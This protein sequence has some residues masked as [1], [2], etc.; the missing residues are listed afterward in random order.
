[1][2]SF[3]VRA[4]TEPAGAVLLVDATSEHTGSDVE[5]FRALLAYLFH[6]PISLVQPRTC[7]NRLC[8]RVGRHPH[9]LVVTVLR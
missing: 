9:G 1:M 5:S 6:V 2:N 3:K 8:E 7:D 4:A